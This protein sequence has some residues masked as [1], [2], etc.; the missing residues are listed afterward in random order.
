MQEP[1]TKFAT[2]KNQLIDLLHDNEAL[3]ELALR[4]TVSE[5][6]A[7]PDR[8]ERESLKALALVAAKKH[9]EALIAYEKLISTYSSVDDVDD[10]LVFLFRNG[11]VHDAI[12]YINVFAEQFETPSIVEHAVT[13]AYANADIDRLKKYNI[14]HA[15]YFSFDSR[16]ALLERGD[17][18]ISELELFMSSAGCSPEDIR[19]L[20]KYAFDLTAHHKLT[21]CGHKY[22]SIDEQ[23]FSV[24]DLYNIEAEVLCDINFSLACGIAEDEHLS[25]LNLSAFFR[26]KDEEATNIDSEPDR[27]TFNS[28]MLAQSEGGSSGSNGPRFR[29]VR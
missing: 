16:A 15:K 10:F 3:N 27:S 8:H 7:I 5:I 11:R 4:R 25:A 29:I 19:Q 28:S 1:A 24:I 26:S 12:N 17:E 21:C 2:I 13:M 20:N 23:N 22:Y 9:E 18:M 14:K 6:S